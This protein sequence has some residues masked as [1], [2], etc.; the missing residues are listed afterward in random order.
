[1]ELSLSALA[2]AS[3]AADGASMAAEDASNGLSAAYYDP[4]AHPDLIWDFALDAWPII[5]A[6]DL[7]AYRFGLNARKE[8]RRIFGERRERAIERKRA[9]GFRQRVINELVRS[10]LPA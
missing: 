4:L 6:M 5:K 10:K 9:D 1:M 7:Q 2:Y 3:S 8:M